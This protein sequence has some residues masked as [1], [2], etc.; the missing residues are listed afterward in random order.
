[1]SEELNNTADLD[2]ST[3]TV[4]ESPASPYAIDDVP[5]D[6]AKSMLEGDAE[7]IEQKKFFTATE[8]NEPA[9]GDVPAEKAAENT[10]EEPPAV[11]TDGEFEDNVIPGVKGEHIKAMPEDVRVALANYYQK[12]Q[13]VL[14]KATIAEEKLSALRSDPIVKNREKLID[15]GRAGLK[16]EI[17]GLTPEEKNSI[18]K[19]ALLDD[20]EFAAI[21]SKIE[22]I[23]ANKARA[24]SY[25]QIVEQKVE[26]EVAE[27][28]KRGPD[29]LLGLSKY[30]P[31]IAIKEKNLSAILEQ[32]EK[33]PEWKAYSEGVG[34]ARDW[35]IKRGMKYN[36]VIDFVDK[37]GEETLYAAIARDTGWT[38]AINTGERDKQ[39]AINERQKALKPFL[40]SSRPKGLP[41]SSSDAVRKDQMGGITESGF[42]LV[43][44]ATD[45]E[46]YE[47][48]VNAK[49]G[50]ESHMTKIDL[51]KEKGSKLLKNS[52]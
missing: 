48:A 27:I 51:L 50:D 9:S 40:K 49:Y 43:K 7:Y 39:I 29:I 19:A 16:Y 6:F 26:K 52:K 37:F 11:S 44:L 20:D 4:T 38:V 30:N 5:D 23:A 32:K 22:E 34:L 46:Y 35:A 24:I 8:K 15:A 36:D 31:K 17:P 45:P 47:S 2:Q 18:K 13:E 28:N 42:D 1:M 25:N 33:H 41:V 12:N 3:E 10:T 14:N 21:E